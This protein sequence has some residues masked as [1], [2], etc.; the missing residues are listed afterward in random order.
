MNGQ[1]LKY[2]EN[3][4]RMAGFRFL[5]DALLAKSKV[6]KISLL[7]RQQDYLALRHKPDL[8]ALHYKLNKHLLRSS[9]EWDSYDYG[10]GYFYQGLDLIGLS[11]LRNTRQRVEAM[12]LTERLCGKRVLEIGCNS[13]FMALSVAESAERVVGFD[14]N[15]H[16]IQIARDTA[17]YLELNNTD[18]E[19]CRFEDFKCDDKFDVV[20]S[21][22]N[23]STYDG[24]TEYS[25]RNYFE[26]CKDLLVPGGSFLFESHPPAHEGDGLKDVC[27][28][29]GEMFDVQHQQVLNYGSF[30]DQGRTFMT[31]DNTVEEAQNKNANIANVTEALATSLT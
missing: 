3:Y 15:P 23:H 22:A 17:D 14:I 28:I 29:I 6:C 4:S 11:G 21:F 30:L 13:G 9:E 27:A 31:A 1:Y 7:N 2:Y 5:W 19:V 25:L 8:L 24:N 20:L 18:F 12:E 10:E 16:L 26:R